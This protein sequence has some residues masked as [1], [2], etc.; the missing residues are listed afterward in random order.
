M[1]RG[2]LAAIFLALG[3]YTASAL[4]IIEVKTGAEGKWSDV[5]TEFKKSR[6]N[7]DLYLGFYNGV[8]LAGGKDV[9]P[10]KIK[11]ISVKYRDND[12]SV[13]TRQLEEKTFTGIAAN[14]PVATEN[15]TFGRA[16]WGAGN[17]F[18]EVTAAVKKII[19]NGKE[20]TLTSD[21]LGVKDPCP[22]AAKMLVV[23]YSMK[24]EQICD[25]FEERTPFKGSSINGVYDQIPLAK[26][27]KS[28]FRGMKLDTAVWQWSIPMA[29]TCNP[30]NNLQSTAF[31]YIPPQTK[32]L[33]GVVV[34]QYN[35]LE[36]PIMEH[37]KFR[38]Y[39]QKLDYGEIWIA[40]SPFK[41]KPFNG[42]FDFRN[43]EQAKA[44]DRM[45]KDLA[46]VSGYNELANIP[47]VGLGHSAMADFPYQ[48][49]AWQPER[50]IAGISFDGAAPGVAYNFE[51]GKV[52]ILNDAA[53]TRLEGIPLLFRSGGIGGVPNLRAIVARKAHPRLALTVIMDPGSGH[54]DINDNIIDYMG[55]YLEK[56]D[57]ARGVGT[58]PLKKVDT[59]KGWFVDYWR[60]NDPPGVKAA[61]VG[62]FQA[63]KGQ[64]GDEANWVFDAEHAQFHEAHEALYRGKKVQLL[65]YVQKGK[66][67]PDIKDHFQIHPNFIP[68][69]DGQSFKVK[70]TFIDVVTDGRAPGWT[71][72]KA[73]EKIEHG[74]DPQNIHIYPDCGPVVRIDDE[75]MA[76]HF[77]RFGFT[78]SGRT[79]GF[80]MIAVHAGDN[81]YRRCVL[82]SATNAPVFNKTGIRQYIDFPA[83]PD[84]KVGT[85]SIK[86]EAKCNTGMPVEYI[87]VHGPAYLCDNELI[88]T[89][90]PA[91]ARYPVDVEVIAYQYGTA[92]AP[93]VRSA[94]PVTRK[95]KIIE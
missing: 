82:Q 21:V 47:F 55:K 83:I 9:A 48:I 7:D 69:K 29:G 77:D 4:E 73:G 42:Q 28:P 27:V 52:P 62:N 14:T 45:F 80:S 26:E 86:L 84:V 30:E 38:E 10:G 32:H 3:T 76:L 22:G 16:F 13:R 58:R 34:G 23:F 70:A 6:I 60:Y 17:K 67:L 2:W 61:P 93:Q 56:A 68:E 19:A 65:G 72:K 94:Q 59:Q 63:K 91:G 36:R 20:V 85:A 57:R 11:Q 90:V 33:R 64:Y 51:Y 71:G 35:M 12:G 78:S 75:T 44:I 79:G 31:L 18:T 8:V 66:V 53:L 40:P 92:N 46:T 5:T 50:A 88:F 74:N 15:F 87:V 43:P 49:A 1:N 25:T 81:V 39:M 24:N 89:P 41:G 37:P 54:F 95:F